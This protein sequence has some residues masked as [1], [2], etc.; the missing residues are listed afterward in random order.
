ME[1][2]L[3]LKCIKRGKLA[4]RRLCSSEFFRQS[5]PLPRKSFYPTFETSTHFSHVCTYLEYLGIFKS[6]FRAFQRSSFVF[7]EIPFHSNSRIFLS[8][9][10]FFFFLNKFERETLRRFLRIFESR[11]FLLKFTGDFGRERIKKW[12]FMD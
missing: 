11:K 5:L 7:Q 6:H 9:S 2:V 1:M 4:E 8:F 10:L 3:K 12:R